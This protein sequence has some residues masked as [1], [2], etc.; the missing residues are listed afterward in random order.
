MSKRTWI[1][2]IIIL[3]ALVLTCEWSRP[4][5]VLRSQH[6]EPAV[7]LSLALASQQVVVTADGKTFHKPGCRFIHGKAK[8]IDAA[9]AAREGYSPCVRCER[10]VLPK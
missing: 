7:R 3:T 4:A 8:L 2:A 5:P 1:G 6:A 10:A 9:Q